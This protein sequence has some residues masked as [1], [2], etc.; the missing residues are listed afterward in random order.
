VRE[1]LSLDN[2]HVINRMP[3]LLNEK[4]PNPNAALH[5]LNNVM[6]ACSALAGH[7]MDDMTRDEGWQFLMVGRHIERMAHLANLF[8]QFLQLDAERQNA[9]LSWLLEAPAVS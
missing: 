6:Q 4:I 5:V 2:W 9:A 3:A 8:D 1:H 7:A